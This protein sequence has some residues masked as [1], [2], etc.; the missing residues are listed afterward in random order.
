MSRRFPRAFRRAGV[1]I[2]QIAFSLEVTPDERNE[3]H[4]HGALTL[5]GLSLAA[6]KDI[7]R[8][9]AGVIEGR[10]GSR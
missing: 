4:V 10:A 8:D 7:L 9:A 5:A 3:L 2:P 1:S 6:V